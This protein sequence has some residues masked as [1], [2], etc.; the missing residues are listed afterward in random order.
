MFGIDDAIGAA[1]GAV[2]SWFGQDDANK[3]NRDIAREQ[4]KFQERSARE[5]M[6]F[7]ERMSS[8]AWQ[9]GV[10]DM[11][12]AGINPMLAFA[13]G[14]AS[15]PSGSSATG[16]SIP[17][18]SKA[19]AAITSALQASRIQADLDNIRSLTTKTQSD[20]DLNRQLIDTSK[21]SAELNTA[22]ARVADATAR[23]ANANAANIATQLPG[24]IKEQKIDE[25]TFGTV[26]RYLG[27][28]NPF[29]HSASSLTQAFKYQPFKPFK[30]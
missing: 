21:S 7:Q 28:L 2:G 9:R 8:T 22:N 30:R 6:A 23:V 27:R 4:M 25:S 29:A 15:S 11:K 17:M 5:S 19:Q 14:G 3:A 18:Q 12:K 24:L 10:E 26:M 20:A 1:V 16:A 13:K